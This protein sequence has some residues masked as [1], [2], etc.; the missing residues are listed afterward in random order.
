M[1][2]I[3]ASSVCEVSFSKHTPLQTYSESSVSGWTPRRKFC[4]PLSNHKRPVCG[5]SS[6]KATLLAAGSTPPSTVGGHS[7]KCDRLH[8]T[9]KEAYGKPHFQGDHTPLMWQWLISFTATL[10]TTE[11][12]CTAKLTQTAHLIEAVF[13]LVV[14]PEDTDTSLRSIHKTHIA[15]LLWEWKR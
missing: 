1:S 5:D 3:T 10:S 13:T 2:N 7:C 12:I 15:L 8:F 14:H 9:V 11:H 6:L 4:L